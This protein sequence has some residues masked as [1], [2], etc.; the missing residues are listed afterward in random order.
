MP[1]VSK[2]TEKARVNDS[3]VNA[4]ENAPANAATIQGFS[5]VPPMITVGA[6]KPS[7]TAYRQMAAATTQPVAVTSE[8][9]SGSWNSST[10]LLLRRGAALSRRARHLDH[11]GSIQRVAQAAD[12]LAAGL[13]RRLAQQSIEVLQH[14]LVFG[15]R[16]LHGPSIR[17]NS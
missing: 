3:A 10:G 14:L 13:V 11:L 5:A 6:L 4:T 17:A 2:R 9:S 16:F 15:G 1:S 7:T 8:G 12:F